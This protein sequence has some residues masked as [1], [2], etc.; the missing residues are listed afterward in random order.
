MIG[1]THNFLFKIDSQNQGQTYNIDQAFDVGQFNAI[2]VQNIYLSKNTYQL[3][4]D[5]ILTIEDVNTEDTYSAT[6]HQGNISFPNLIKS[7]TQ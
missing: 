7:L 5:L 2:S 1:K 6:I 4:E 3:N